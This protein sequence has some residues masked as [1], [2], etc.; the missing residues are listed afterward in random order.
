M[1]SV[2]EAGWLL[3]FRGLA[4]ARNGKQDCGNV[5]ETVKEDK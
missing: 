4:R 3:G 5:S 2:K 1:Q